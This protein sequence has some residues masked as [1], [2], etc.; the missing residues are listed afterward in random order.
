MTSDHDQRFKMLLKEF[1][2]EF[3][4]LF[5]PEWA[6]LF[7]FN[8]TEWLDTET[9]SDPPEGD[10]RMLDLVAKL[11]CR[12]DDSNEEPEEWLSLIHIEV[13]SAT[14]I[15]PLRRRMHRYY[16]DLRQRHDLPV[17][18]VALYLR[19][20]MDGI[21]VDEYRES[22]NSFEILHF[23]Y[24]YVGLSQLDG[25]KY[26]QQKN[27]LASA[28]A[29]LMKQPTELKPLHK[30]KAMEEI[31][32][33]NQ[34]EFRK[35]LL[36]ECVEAYFDLNTPQQQKEFEL[37]LNTQEYQEAKIMG[38]TS[39]E[40]GIAEGIEQG[41]EQGQSELVL[42]LLTVQFGDVDEQT[43]EDLKNWTGDYSILVKRILKADCLE[44][45]DLKNTEN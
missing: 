20:G 16:T 37:L 18:P 10:R 4:E 15:A 9:F 7:Q 12:D 26:S 24:L 27:I 11:K 33:S 22:F 40:I 43:K 3:F 32:A 1:L 2:P 35:Y 5:F 45:V 30:V 36:L 19:V 23:R 44:D 34:N 28:F 6:K 31:S 38:I 17:L 13:E 14:T 42:Q 29:G 39:R 21:G 41:I 25:V 8:Q